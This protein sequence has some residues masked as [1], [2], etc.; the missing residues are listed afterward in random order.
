MELNKDAKKAY[1]LQDYLK[2]VT[3]KDVKVIELVSNVDE[4]GCLIELMRLGEEIKKNIGDFD[5]RQVN[6]SEI[7]PGCIKAF[8]VHK[9]QT[10]IWFTPPSDKILLVLADVREASPTEGNILRLTL[11]G[12]KPRLVVI[13]PGVAHGCRN[14]KNSP[15]RIIYF[16]N[17]YFS[18][19]PD[20][21]DEGRL[22]WYFFGEKIWEIKRD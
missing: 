13:P 2:K 18:T 9:I 14:L 6:Y 16:T 3:I 17:Y 12:G 1:V 15:S 5:L 11:G 10:D 4:S 8:H 19:E 7:D 20:K 22:P 21:C